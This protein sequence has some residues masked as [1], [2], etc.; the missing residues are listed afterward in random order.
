VY[1]GVRQV[2]SSVEPSGPV[3]IHST[4]GSIIDN[5]TF[6]LQLAGEGSGVDMSKVTFAV[7]TPKQIKIFTNLDPVNYTWVKQNTNHDIGQSAHAGLL[8]AREMVLVTIN[9][10][11]SSTDLGINTRFICEVRPPNSASLQIMRIIPAGL[12][13]DQWYEVY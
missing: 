8:G 2:T 1:S 4:D 12:A 10:G 13:A 3:S 11:F 5:I 6:Y 9:P 7:S